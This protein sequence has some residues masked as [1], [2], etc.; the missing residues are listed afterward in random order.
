VTKITSIHPILK[1]IE[2]KEEFIVID[3]SDY[4]VVDYVFQTPTT[5]DDPLLMECRGIKFCKDDM[6]LARPV[7]SLTTERTVLVS[8]STARTW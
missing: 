7:S 6:I 2:G 8:R 5:F 1:A 4:K 3:K